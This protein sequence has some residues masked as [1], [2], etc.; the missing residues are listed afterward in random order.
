MI[1]RIEDPNVYIGLPY[2]EVVTQIESCGYTPLLL[3]ANKITKEII[4]DYDPL[5]V[6]LVT[7]EDR[8]TEAKI[9]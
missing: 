4:K 8:V 6:Q 1:T 3:R 2:G 7:I 5:R 9:G